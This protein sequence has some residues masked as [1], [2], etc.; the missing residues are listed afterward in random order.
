MTALALKASDAAAR[1]RICVDLI[2]AAARE[3]AKKATDARRAELTAK[4]DALWVRPEPKVGM[5][6][7]VFKG[8]HADKV[9]TLVW[10]G[11]TIW[12]SR[13]ILA[14]TDNKLPNGRYADAIYVPPS[15]VISVNAERDEKNNEL[16]AEINNLWVYENE[17]FTAELLRLYEEAAKEWGFTRNVLLTRTAECINE[18]IKHT[19]DYIRQS[20][21]THWA[22]DGAAFNQ[23]ESHLAALDREV[24]ANTVTLTVIN[25]NNA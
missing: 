15:H 6:Y 22:C 18:K 13:Y 20:G 23:V 17:T 10:M 21:E 5:R 1:K 14:L 25:A 4:R 24:K 9:G 7:R 19:K 3:A 2:P 16:L 12:G 11:E 8:N